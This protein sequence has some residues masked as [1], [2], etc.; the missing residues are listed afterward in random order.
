[1]KFCRINLIKENNLKN[2]IPYLTLKKYEKGSYI[3]KFRE[4]SNAA[5]YLI[6][7]K[8]S[9]KTPRI[10]NE[11]YSYNKFLNL[12]SLSSLIDDENNDSHKIYNINNTNSKEN[13]ENVNSKK[14][15]NYN[16]NENENENLIQQEIFMKR[17]LESS[18]NILKDPSKKLCKT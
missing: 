15:D 18:L 2:I 7:G 10:S 12:F 13:I 17:Y 9:V 1:M 16:D 14:S 5:Y 6:K 3:F 8:I 4:N 11:I